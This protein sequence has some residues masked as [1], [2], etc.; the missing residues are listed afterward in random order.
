[1]KLKTSKKEVRAYYPKERIITLSYCDLQSVLN[2][3]N[4]FAYSC[5]VYG[6]SCDYYEYRGYCISTGYAPVE[7]VRLPYEFI[8]FLEAEFMVRTKHIFGYEKTKEVANDIL[9]LLIEEVQKN[10]CL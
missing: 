3:Y 5:G 7:G 9:D 6:W 1:M 4:A 2:Y 8:R 10:A